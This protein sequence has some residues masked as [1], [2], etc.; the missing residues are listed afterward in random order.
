[1]VWNLAYDHII[2]WILADSSRLQYLNSGIAKRYPK[3]GI[4]VAKVDDLDDLKESELI[5]ACRTSE[6]LNKNTIAI[7][8]D[9]L[10]RRNAVAHPSRITVT[11][12]QAD[13]AIS[14]LVLN[15]ILV[16]T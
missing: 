15:V 10:T 6:L 13:D 11:Q 4:V 8:R 12:H 3:K 7:L 14:D 2:R 1:M 16:L 5:E 9:K